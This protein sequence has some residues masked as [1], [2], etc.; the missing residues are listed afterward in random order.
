VVFFNQKWVEIGTKASVESTI[1]SITGINNLAT[2][3]QA[4]I[5]QKMSWASRRQTTRV[6]DI[7]YCLMGLF[8]VNMAPLYG[9]GGNAFRRLQLEII[10]RLDDESIFAWVDGV[11]RS[12]GGL[13]ARSPSCFKYSGDIIALTGGKN[14]SPFSMTNRGLCIELELYVPTATNDTEIANPTFRAPIHCKREN[15]SNLLA[16]SLVRNPI[17]QYFR[18]ASF[19]DP[20]FQHERYKRT[21][22]RTVYVWQPDD[23]WYRQADKNQRQYVFSIHTQ[24]AL[25]GGFMLRERLISCEGP[26]CHSK[27]EITNSEIKLVLDTSDPGPTFYG[28]IL[29]KA[30]RP[31]RRLAVIL[32]VDERYRPEAEFLTLFEKQSL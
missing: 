19:L 1:T 22:R 28:V 31:K 18:L 4:S 2:F 27:W 30:N 26:M 20:Y 32:Q 11:G 25:Q 5:A 15:N 21:T 7:A 9:E 10:S 6:E 23:D 8:G 13:L 29:F 14:R 3:E 16:L 12:I 24:S 17:D